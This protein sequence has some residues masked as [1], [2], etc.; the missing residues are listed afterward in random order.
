MGTPLRKP[1]HV[2]SSVLKNCHNWNLRSMDSTRI[3]WACALEIRVKALTLKLRCNSLELETGQKRGE[4]IGPFRLIYIY[5]YMCVCVY[6]CMC[7]Y[8]HVIYIYI[9]IYIHLY[10]LINI[11]IHIYIYILIYIYL[12]IYLFI[13][14]YIFI[15]K[16]NYRYIIYS[17]HYKY[18]WLVLKNASSW[19]Q[20]NVLPLGIVVQNDGL[21]H[22]RMS[23]DMYM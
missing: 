1:P 7:V 6:T 8:I 9:Y 11:Y 22:H 16:T 10:I 19:A 12:Y 2:I 17:Y 23:A 4:T 5:I 13:Y 18:N 15:R 14:I 3:P 20:T 21:Y